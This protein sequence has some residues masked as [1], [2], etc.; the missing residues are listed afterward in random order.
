MALSMIVLL[1]VAAR[2]GHEIAGTVG[3]IVP[4]AVFLLIEAE[5]FWGTRPKGSSSR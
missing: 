4:V 2:F 3:A 5:L 1:Y